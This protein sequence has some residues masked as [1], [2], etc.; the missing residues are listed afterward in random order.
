MGGICGGQ[1]NLT[2]P[3]ETSELAVVSIQTLINLLSP[4]FA[5]VDKITP[6]LRGT[7]TRLL[8]DGK[9]VLI[10]TTI[11]VGIMSFIA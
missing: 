4:A 1:R 9:I 8:L 10:P 6:N 11:K 2:P 7:T 3:P 5:S